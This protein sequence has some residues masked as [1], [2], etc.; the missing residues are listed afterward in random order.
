MATIHQKG[1]GD[2]RRERDLSYR[3]GPVVIDL[4]F[5]RQPADLIRTNSSYPKK[6]T[7]G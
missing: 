2:A 7:K 5:K 4:Q 1:T 3:L 6:V